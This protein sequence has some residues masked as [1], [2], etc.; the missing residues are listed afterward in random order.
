M[1]VWLP[2]VRVQIIA[3]KTRPNRLITAS[4][5]DVAGKRRARAPRISLI[6]PTRRPVLLARFKTHH[7]PWRSVKEFT[8]TIGK[9]KLFLVNPVRFEP[10][11]PYALQNMRNLIVI[12]VSPAK[13]RIFIFHFV[14]AIIKCFNNK[15]F[16]DALA[17]IFR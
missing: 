14:I 9:S 11:R 2:K 13:L 10:S 5:V 3:A 15:T 6:V 7:S 12:L 4:Q 8:K 16:R 1:S 17:A